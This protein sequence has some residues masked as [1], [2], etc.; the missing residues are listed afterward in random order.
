[1]QCLMVRKNT[2][3]RMLETPSM[4][5]SK[6]SDGYESLEDCGK[7]GRALDASEINE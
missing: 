6:G 3:T 5:K 1:M 2:C 4:T 7:G